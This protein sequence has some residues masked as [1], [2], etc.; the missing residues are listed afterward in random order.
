MQGFKSFAKRTE[1]P[2]DN[3]LSVIIGPNGS[4]KCVTGDT[5]VQLADGSLI[6]IND[7]VNKKVAQKAEKIEDGFIAEGDSTKILTMNLETQKIEPKPIRKYVKRKSPSRLMYIK[8]RS[9]RAIK[10]TK[11]HPLFVLKEGKIESLKAEEL[12]KG[13]R[14]AVPRIINIEPRTKYFFELLNLIKAED[15]IYVPWNNQFSAMLLKIKQKKTWKDI[16]QEIGIPLNSIKGLLD[17]QAINFEYLIKILRRSKMSDSEII[18]LIPYVKS[19]KSNKYKM[20][21]KNSPEF[22]RFLGYLLA[23]GRLPQTSNQI[24][25][26]NG[27][28]EVVADYKRLI[29][30]LFEVN[31]NINEYKPNCWDILA[32]SSPIRKILT[33]FGMPIGVT[34]DKA[35]TDLLLIHSSNEEL[36]ELLNGLYCGDGYV[37]DKSIE[38]TTKSKSLG[39]AIENV[40][41][42]LGIQASSNFVIKTSTNSGFSGIYKTIVISGSDNFRLFSQHISLVHKEKQQKMDR[43]ITLKSN[44]NVD[45]IEANSMIKQLVKELGINIKE[46]KKEFPRLDSYCYNQCIPSRHGLQYLM[47]NLFLKCPITQ[48]TSISQLRRLCS[49]DI[50]WDEI[51]ELEEFESNEEWVYDLCID[52]N[53]N[54]IA[55]NFFVHNSNITDAICFVLGRLSIKSMRASR[56]SNLIHNGGKGG[57]PAPEAFVELVLDNANRT[58]SLDKKDVSVSRTVRRNGISIYKINGETKTRQ[59]VLELLSQAGVDP[60]GFNIILQEEISRFVEMHPE[61]R[62][63]ILEQVAGISVYEERKHKSMNELARTEEKLKEIRTILNERTSYLK[64]LDKERSQALSHER[65]KKDIERDKAALLFRS[66]EEKRREEALLSEKI[67]E[68][69]KS[70]IKSKHS[71]SSFEEK[72][73]RLNEKIDQINLHVE[74]ATGIESEQLHK[75]IASSRAEIAALSVKMENYSDQSDNLR[76]RQKQLK[77]SI[78]K[79]NSEIDDLRKEKSKLKPQKQELDIVSFRRE[80]SDAISKLKKQNKELFSCFYNLLDKVRNF[81]ELVAQNPMKARSKISEIKSVLQEISSQT[82]KLD[83]NINQELKDLENLTKAKISALTEET[84]TKLNLDMEISLRQKEIEKTELIIKRSDREIEELQAALEELKVQLKEKEAFAKGK[85]QYENKVYS[86]FQRMFKNRTALQDS[87]RKLEQGLMENRIKLRKVE[88]EQNGLR[89]AKAKTDAELETLTAEF[90]QYKH[91]SIESL[92]LKQSRTEIES[93]IKKNEVSL[94]QLGTV[95]LRALEVYDKVKEEYDQ[96]AEKVQKLEEEKT[97]IL[98]VIFEIDKKKKTSFMKVFTNINSLFSN[99]F[100]RL[101]GR[102]AF[103]DLENNENPFEGGINI[104]VRIGKGKYLDVNSLSGGERTLVA[105]SLIFAIQE[106]KPYYFYIFDEI[107]AALDKRNSE[108]LSGLLRSNIRNAQYVVIT[109]NDSLI[110]DSPVLFGVS[111]QEGKSK[112]LSLKF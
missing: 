96:V 72:I 89:I 6:R 31:S 45:L 51:M 53:H 67:S 112:V 41:L 35:I 80:L 94:I 34:K 1:V 28:E 40:L 90:E 79:N 63:K 14:I 60:N 8:T 105:L 100:L 101:V 98:N 4:G 3:G 74:K 71:I 52:K 42:R 21:W 81:N 64:N 83:L 102:E 108:R 95:N 15:R 61:E 5:L 23:E 86:N 43:L 59:E 82:Q 103:L 78:R 48:N 38:I 54:F 11:Y 36:S 33:K 75:E 49:S 109:H 2:F 106:F 13:L 56:A 10:A 65:M 19:D 18:S 20:I 44:P 104:D 29:D 70:T 16:A 32:Y 107:D 92:R 26:T 9:G 68:K 50:F 58:F 66:L 22:A 7:L 93:R 39:A 27:T 97:E 69:E 12:R 76:E 47:E 111:M 85:E 99:N 88:D 57:P 24:W 17:K 55:N 25:F 84:E 30:S 77:E 46:N 62:R 73:S 91:F 37:S 110:S 87:I